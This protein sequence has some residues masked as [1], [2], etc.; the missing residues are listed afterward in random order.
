MS[1]RK[2]IY[3]GIII[4]LIFSLILSWRIFSSSQELKVYFLDVG[5]GDAILISQGSQQ[6][7]IDGGPSE[8]VLLEKLGQFIPFWD[9]KIETLIATHP[10]KDHIAGLLAVMKNYQVGALINSRVPQESEI[11]QEFEKLIS[12]EKITEIAG[13]P[14][15][16]I[17]WPDGASL[18]ILEAK[19][20]KDTNQGSI[21]ARL[22]FGEDSFLFTG[23]ITENEEKDLI[24][25][26]PD[27]LPAD[28]L[29]IAHH[30]SKYATSAEFL[31]SVKPEE[32]IIS[33]GQNNR[34][35]HPTEE[36]LSRLG[37]KGITILRTDQS[38]DIIYDCPEMKKDCFR[39]K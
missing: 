15:L 39:E 23:D 38:G 25:K 14:G 27:A 35:G 6:V 32:A 33:V 11:S 34:Y 21:V 36:V 28:F 8:Q 19:I 31:D 18:K 2:L 30:G 17:N 4:L 5:Q 9:R 16:K 24:S 37:E 29:K 10:D 12:Q 26:I 13:E 1:R 20:A 7:L 22:D 3:S